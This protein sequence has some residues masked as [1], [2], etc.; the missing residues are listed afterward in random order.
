MS[1]N[2]KKLGVG[3]KA[4]AFSAILTVIVIA[5]A[6]VLNLIVNSLPSKFTKFD[7]TA[8]SVFTFDQKTEKFISE[9]ST[10]VTVYHIVESGAEDKYLTEVLS[11]YSEMN[12]HISVKKIDPVKQPTF[13]EKYTEDALTKNSLIVES[14]ARYKVVPFEDIYYIYC[15]DLG[16]SFDYSTFEYYYQMY[17]QYYGKALSYSE[18]FAGENAV[19]GAI[20]YVTTDKLP[21]VYTISGHGEAALNSAITGWLEA[22]NYQ[23]ETFTIT[24]SDTALGGNVTSKVNDIPDDAGLV[25]LITPKT[26][27]TTEECEVLTKYVN[28]G[29]R[30]IVTSNYATSSLENFRAL[31]ASLGL[32]ISTSVL[33]E[34]DASYY[35]SAKY[36]VK[37]H[38]GS[39]SITSGLT[40][41]M[42]PS[43]YGI[44]IKETLPEDLKATQLL[45]TSD[46]S[47]AKPLGFDT[48]KSLEREEG[49]INGPFSLA[50]LVENEK[51]QGAACWFSSDS[52]F[53]YSQQGE[54]ANMFVGAVSTLCEKTETIS[55][56]TIELSTSFLEITEGSAN[57]WGVLVIGI[58]PLSFIVCGF[59]VWMRRRSR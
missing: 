20:D 27:L 58:I 42:M 50:V 18:V 45:Y 43:A 39:H 23:S 40:S 13:I 34:T 31:A 57:I 25:L 30:L 47:Y 37:A 6:I 16:Q 49:D 10:D 35:T 41:V 17:Y 26:D 53:I 21:K 8:N 15:S 14:A 59:V 9:L 32:D 44:K 12:S 24:E 46:N 7:T 29:G 55:V 4:G 36:N 2:N 52:Y 51:T 3:V 11:R 38:I 48:S 22:Q 33:L 54:A 19:A 28:G 5:A 1:K 56:H